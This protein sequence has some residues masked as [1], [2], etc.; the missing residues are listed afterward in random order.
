MQPRCRSEYRRGWGCVYCS[1]A[2]GSEDGSSRLVDTQLENVAIELSHPCLLMMRYV[3][4][5][6][7]VVVVRMLRRRMGITRSTTAR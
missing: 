3:S 2:D 1:I 5:V 4:G 6:V 7:M